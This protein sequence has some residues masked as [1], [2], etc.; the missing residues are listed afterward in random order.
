MGWELQ[1][2]AAALELRGKL[3]ASA[4]ERMGLPG[5]L[6]LML[7]HSKASTMMDHMKETAEDMDSLVK[8]R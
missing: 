4:A 1:L 5:K 2:N 7:K 6:D 3:P 8:R